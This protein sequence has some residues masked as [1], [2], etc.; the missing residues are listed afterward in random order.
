[1]N[2]RFRNETP[3]AGST[4]LTVVVLVGA[5]T[6]LTLVFL[7]IGQRVTDEQLATVESARA[8][9]LAEAGIAEALEALRSGKSGNVGAS[10]DPAYLGGGVVWVTATDLGSGRTQLDSLAMKDSGRAALRVVV[11]NGAGGGSG[12]GGGGS[13]GDG[14]FHMLFSNK[15]LQLDQSVMID[16]YDSSLG[17]YASQATNTH[18][19]TAYAGANGGA[20]GNST[21]QLDT[22][23]KVFGDVHSGPNDSVSMS[24]GAYVSGSTTPNPATVPLAPVTVPVVSSSGAYSVANYQSKTLSAGTYHFTSVTMGKFSSLTINGP[25]TLVWDGFTT[26]QSA[27]LNVDC[28]NGPVIIY[29]TGV[30]SVDKNFV[31]GPVPG[32]PVDASFLISSTGTVQFDQGSKIYVGFYAPNAKIQ[33]D[34]GAEVWGAL[35]A[36]EISVDQGTKFHFDENLRGFEL[37][38]DVPDSILGTTGGSEP[39]I[40]SWMKIDFPVDLYA[41]DRR[42]PFSVLGVKKAE[43]RSPAEAW[44]DADSQ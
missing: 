15:H 18:G 20:S 28:T 26:G 17:T 35:A 1:M 8:S 4:L 27:T 38:W 2:V 37:P 14:F 5:L 33:V 13:A 43:L 19:G 34:Q 32:S 41:A 31:V 39:Q 16:S 22:N 44:E 3:R 9:Y 23:V 12:S 29:D 40:V 30:W 11:E 24:G 6:V 10:D 42:D 21:I 36:D 25:A 7:R